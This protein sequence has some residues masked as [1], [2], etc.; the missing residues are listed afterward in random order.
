MCLNESRMFERYTE[1]ARR[2]IFFARALALLS[3]ANHIDSV[4]LLRGLFF[5]D[6]TR[7]QSLFQL[8]EFFPIYMG[9]PRKYTKLPERKDS[10]PLT[11]NSK[12]ILAWTAV[13]ANRL[14]DY[15]ID[16]E[17]LLLGILRA[18]GSTGRAYLL[19]TGLTV[20]VARRTI[21]ENISSRPAYGDVPFSWKMKRPLL[22]L[23]SLWLWS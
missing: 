2:A 22:R 8:R 7:A 16:T 17:H 1:P 10:P 15:W 4:D 3:D 20:R 11:N 14:G 21:K 18:T 9:C 23:N 13:E 12:M 6:G 19:R 5:E